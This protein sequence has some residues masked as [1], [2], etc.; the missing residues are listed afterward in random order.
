MVENR[1]LSPWINIATVP[2]V[3]GRADNHSE[4]SR[5]ISRTV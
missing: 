5:K 3:D 1:I 2:L 4:K